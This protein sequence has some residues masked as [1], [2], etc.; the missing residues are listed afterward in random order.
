MPACNYHLHFFWKNEVSIKMKGGDLKI[1]FT[2]EYEEVYLCGDVKKILSCS[3]E[4]KWINLG[5]VLRAFRYTERETVNT[6]KK[7]WVYENKIKA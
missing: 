2:K 1:Q 3:Y 5:K 6:P 4:I 7:V